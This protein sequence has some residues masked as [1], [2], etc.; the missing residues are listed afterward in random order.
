MKTLLLTSEPEV[1]EA[2]KALKEALIL[3]I[4]DEECSYDHHGCCQAHRIG[5][6]CENAL[7][8]EALKKAEDLG[9]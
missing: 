2:V 7:G 5:D 4:D 6:P 9:I 1:Q 8:K 3:F